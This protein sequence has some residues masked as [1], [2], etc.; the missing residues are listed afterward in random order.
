MLRGN[1]ELHSQVKTSLEEMEAEVL[2]QKE[3][4]QSLRKAFKPMEQELESMEAMRKLS[5][6]RRK[7]AG[8]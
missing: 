6:E 3:I 5:E 2:K 7:S 4:I 1:R 8:D